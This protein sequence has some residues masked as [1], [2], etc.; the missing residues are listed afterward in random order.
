MWDA[1]IQKDL[2]HVGGLLAIMRKICEIDTLSEDLAVLVF[3]FNEVTFANVFLIP[4]PIFSPKSLRVSF[5]K[6]QDH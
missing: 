4:Y 6:S 2:M 1:E 3:V 5:H